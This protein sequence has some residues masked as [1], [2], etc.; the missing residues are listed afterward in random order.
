MA[1]AT[2]SDRPPAELTS[3]PASS[4]ARRVS[5]ENRRLLRDQQNF[6]RAAIY[7]ARH[8]ARIEAVECV[9]LFGSV[10]RALE[11][12][13]PRFAEFRR[14]GIELLHECRDVDLAVWLV[15]ATEEPAFR[16]RF[17]S[18]SVARVR[19]LQE[20]SL[21]TSVGVADH[22]VDVFLF[23]ASD[24]RYLGRLCRFN[25]CP[26][27]RPECGVRDCGSTPFLRQIEGF[28]LWADAL[29]PGRT[30]E[31]FVRRPPAAASPEHS[32]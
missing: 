30:M 23:D 15:D 8:F 13:I 10:A 12:E 32:P 4:T 5:E 11:P 21:A 29:D 27:G 9:V 6:R 18:A 26:K 3:K 17:E 24:H 28:H 31:L 2:M 20:L 1:T 19:A 22:Q 14:A 7:V 16:T 25:R